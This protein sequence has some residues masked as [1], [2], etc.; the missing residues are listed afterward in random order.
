VCTT[1]AALLLPDRLMASVSLFDPRR[2]SL[3]AK[4]PTLPQST[5]QKP[6]HS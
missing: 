3:D 4:Q 2:K 1:A 6:H 5:V